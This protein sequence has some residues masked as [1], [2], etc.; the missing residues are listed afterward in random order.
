MEHTLKN[1]LKND[2]DDPLKPVPFKRKNIG[3]VEQVH[4]YIRRRAGIKGVL[5]N[6]HFTPRAIELR[7]NKAIREDETES[8]SDICSEEISSS[9]E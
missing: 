9:P 8:E 1:T 4:G 6:K 3:Q 5:E 2:I 7:W